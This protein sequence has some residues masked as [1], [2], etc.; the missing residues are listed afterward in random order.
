MRII[1]II[2]IWKTHLNNSKIIKKLDRTP[3][4]RF[5]LAQNLCFK[6]SQ[7]QSCGKEIEN[8]KRKLS[9]SKDSRIISLSPFL[10]ENG[11]FRTNSRITDFKTDELNSIPVI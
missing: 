2:D 3:A 5:S 7:F 6:V 11:V 1:N 10:D 8:L 9:I 4:E